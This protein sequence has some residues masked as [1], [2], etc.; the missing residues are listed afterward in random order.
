MSLSSM[1]LPVRISGPF[2]GRCQNS[3]SGKH[4]ADQTHRIKSDGKWTPGLE[5]FSL[6]GVID[7]GLMV[8]HISAG[9]LRGMKEEQTS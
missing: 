5:L 6:T 1:V 4:R 7:D 3:E 9:V 2:Y 8:L